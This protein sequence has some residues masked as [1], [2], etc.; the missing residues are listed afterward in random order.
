[1]KPNLDDLMDEL[2]RG[3]IWECSLMEQGFQVEGLI[4]G[5]N[6]YIDP[7]PS[8]LDSV[9]HELIHRRYPRLGERTVTKTARKL[10]LSMSEAEKAR[11]WR[12]YRRIRRQGRPVNLEEA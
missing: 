8:V 7:R 1:M 3:K 2:R 11:W 4:S 9:L 6:I 10:M 12:A 5:E